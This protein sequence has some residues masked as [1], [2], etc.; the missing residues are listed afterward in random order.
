M[1]RVLSLS[2][3]GWK[4]TVT[5]SRP[6]RLSW[7]GALHWK[8]FLRPSHGTSSRFTWGDWEP[9]RRNELSKVTL[10]SVRGSAGPRVM[11]ALRKCPETSGVVPQGCF[12]P[13][14]HHL[15]VIT[16]SFGLCAVSLLRDRCL[17]LN[18]S[19]TKTQLLFARWGL[20]S[21]KTWRRHSSCSKGSYI[22]DC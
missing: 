20:E 10:I 22:R 7:L 5:S 8:A 17:I 14:G 18:K 6:S 3:W 16:V 2:A 13:S 9:E 15:T 1:L 4:S 21:S 11:P 12:L 19:Q